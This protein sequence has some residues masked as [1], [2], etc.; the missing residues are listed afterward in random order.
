MFLKCATLFISPKFWHF[1]LFLLPNH[2]LDHSIIFHLSR[3]FM[4]EKIGGILLQIHFNDWSQFGNL[5]L[6]HHLKYFGAIL[7]HTTTLFHGQ[8]LTM[9]L[10]TIFYTPRYFQWCKNVLN[11]SSYAEFMLL[12]SWPTV[13]ITMVRV[14]ATLSPIT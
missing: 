14:D 3:C 1:S 2:E 9:E 5:G 8:N 4:G 6:K 13:L 11:Q 12:A 7:R 10:P